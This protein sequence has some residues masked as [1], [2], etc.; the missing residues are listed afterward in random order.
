MEVTITNYQGLAFRTCKVYEELPMNLLHVAVGVH[1]EYNE[2]QIA[3]QNDDRINVGEEIGD[4]FWYL[5]VFCQFKNIQLFPIVPNFT[6]RDLNYWTSKFSN[7]IK[8]EAIYN[9]EQDIN[10]YIDVLQK[11][12]Y[13]LVNTLTTFDIKTTDSLKANINKLS[14]RYKE[15]YTDLQAQERDLDEEANQLA[16]HLS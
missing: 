14:E 4:I 16:K 12:V 5:A 13:V 7:L 10:E 3:I 2:L 9:K 8:R 1:S 15:K 6:S 11:I